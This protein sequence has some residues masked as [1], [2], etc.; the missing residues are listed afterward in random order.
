MRESSQRAPELPVLS[1]FWSPFSISLRF[2][3]ARM[4]VSSFLSNFTKQVVCPTTTALFRLNRCFSLL[5]VKQTLDPIHIETPQQSSFSN[6]EVLILLVQ[7]MGSNS[8]DTSVDV[9]RFYPNLT[10]PISDQP[11]QSRFSFCSF[12]DPT[13]LGSHC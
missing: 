5:P 7:H 12:T 3:G 13:E 11:K 8:I 4:N 10:C 2:S 1:F 6:H 9:Q